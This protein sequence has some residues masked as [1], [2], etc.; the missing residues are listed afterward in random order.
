MEGDQLLTTS[1]S[2][3]NLRAQQPSQTDDA[4]DQ[5]LLFRLPTV[6]NTNAIFSAHSPNLNAED[7]ILLP[8]PP[9]LS[10]RSS[11]T[12]LGSSDLDLGPVK[13]SSQL[14]LPVSN[15]A[16]PASEWAPRQ[17]G[18]TRKKKR[19]KLCWIGAGLGVA[20]VLF[21]GLLGNRVP[22][23]QRRLLPLPPLGAVVGRLVGRVA[24]EGV[25]RV[26]L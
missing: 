6:H 9:L 1:A 26:L 14:A 18:E 7:N 19:S 8:P 21:S 17:L 2:F 10:E 13:E 22:S 20:L 5:N 12:V 16:E 23:L 15:Y 3:P 24:M 11:L 4:V 25:R